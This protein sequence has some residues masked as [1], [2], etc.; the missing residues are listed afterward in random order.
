MIGA[1]CRAGAIAGAS[2]LVVPRLVHRGDG[3]LVHLKLIDTAT[4]VTL[5][6]ATHQDTDQQP[7]AA[8]LN[9]LLQQIDN[10]PTATDETIDLAMLLPNDAQAQTRR[11]PKW[12]AEATWARW[13]DALAS[14]DPRLRILDP[15]LADFVSRD[16]INRRTGLFND[17]KP[18]EVLRSP[19][20]IET[21]L[22][23]PYNSRYAFE[24]APYQLTLTLRDGDWQKVITSKGICEN[25]AQ[26]EAEALNKAL[27]AIA[28]RRN[29]PIK[30]QIKSVGDD[31]YWQARALMYEAETSAALEH[32]SLH[33]KL[34]TA[35]GR[36]LITNV[37]RAV[38]ALPGSKEALS[39]LRQITDQHGIY[40]G[41][42]LPDDHPFHELK[43]LI[44]KHYAGTYLT[45]R[46]L[47]WSMA[48]HLRL[49]QANAK[50][51]RPRG[52]TT[53]DR[54]REAI[55]TGCVDRRVAVVRALLPSAGPCWRG[56]VGDGCGG[57]LSLAAAGAGALDDDE[58]GRERG[59]R[60][61]P[62]VDFA[63]KAYSAQRLLFPS[64]PGER[65]MRSKLVLP[66]L[67]AGRCKNTPL[68]QARHRAAR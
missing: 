30:H 28:Q 53:S 36:E 14:A 4:G 3:Y 25:A 23:A 15:S 41:W 18:A 64:Y 21:Q 44:N 7:I 51:R 20:V 10:A 6:E 58:R 9:Q 38:R 1:S 12:R 65:Y 22:D 13:K 60:G 37:I 17:E 54:T 33:D 5:W 27:A 62:E 47:A 56:A 40:M 34:N 43:D 50:G 67:Q 49:R 42:G 8:L 29:T 11:K 35:D 26:I 57:F 19:I 16:A 52:A 45:G 46:F 55:G 63:F 2:L 61:G 66:K 31:K 68:V 48:R 24:D 59:G 32:G 39:P